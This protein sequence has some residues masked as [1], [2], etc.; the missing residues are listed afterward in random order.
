MGKGMAAALLMATVRSAL[1]AGAHDSPP[2]LAIQSA[3]TALEAD[4]ESSGSFVTLFHA[5]LAAGA[6]RLTYVDAGHGHAFLRH[7]DGGVDELRPRGLPLGVLPGVSYQEGTVIL[8]PG[9]ALVIY[10]D[11]L[12]HA[13]PDL[14]A[15]RTAV[16]GRLEGATGAAAMVDWLVALARAGGFP[17]DDLTVVVLRCVG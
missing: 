9:D 13:C 15:D 17:P 6:R 12:V 7:G 5:R 2:A 1:R 14:G 16:A 10:S 11:G 8:C 4:L 3:A